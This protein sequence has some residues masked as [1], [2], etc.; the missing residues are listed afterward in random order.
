[1]AFES[2]SD[3]IQM[4]KHGLYVWST[5]GFSLVVILAMAWQ[6]LR[7]NRVIRH[8]LQKRFQKESSR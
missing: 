1:M 7:S 4:G 2:F 6:S 8:Q 3:F 5:Y